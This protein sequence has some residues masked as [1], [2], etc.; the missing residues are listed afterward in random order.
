MKS[1]NPRQKLLVNA[2]AAAAMGYLPTSI[3]QNAEDI[4]GLLEEIVVTATAREQTVQEIPYNISAI[5]GADIAASQI[6]GEADLLRSIAGVG[7]IDRGDRNAGTVNSII[8]RGLNVDNGSSGDNASNAVAAVSTYVDN[9]PLYARFVL[10]DIQRVEVLRGPQGT[11]YGS[12]SLGGTVRYISNKPN[13]EE[14][15][16]SV[17]A[18]YGEVNGSGGH[19]QTLDMMLNVP[20]SDQLAIRGHIGKVD[21]DGS[22]D[23]INAYQLNEF[24]EPLLDDG[25][26][27]CLD[28]R[29]A[30][31]Q[32]VLHNVGCFTNR[33]DADTVELEYGRVALQ[34]EPSESLSFLLAYQTQR[35]KVGGRRAI[36]LGDNNQ[37]EGSPLR[38]EYGDDDIGLVLTEPSSRDVDMLA[39]DVE[40]DLGFATL[41]SNTSRYDHEG[42]GERDNGG[43]WTSVNSDGRGD[44][45]SI[46]YPGWARPAHRT[47]A[48][49]KDETFVQ[50]F[51]LVSN[52]SD[53]AFDWLAGVFYLDQEK[54]AYSDSFNPGMNNWS[55]ACARTNDP[56]CAGFWPYLFAAG[57]PL[58]ENDFEYERNETFEELAVYGEVTWHLSQKLRVTGGL[59]WFDNESVADGVMG[60]PLLEGDSS[61]VVQAN[62]DEDSGVLLKVNASYDLSETA[63]VYGTISEGYRRG[64]ANSIPADGPFAEP[65]AEAVSAYERDTVLNYEFGVKGRTDSLAYTLSAFYID[66]ND[67]Q[68]NTASTFG[69]LMADNGD[70]AHTLG[71]E[72][73]LDGYIGN[74]LHYRFGYTWTEAEL[75]SDFVGTQ[76]G[77]VIAEKGERLPGSA[78]HVLSLGIDY[79]W[80]V[81]DGM[82]LVAQANGYY[83]SDSENYIDNDNDPF[84][85]THDGFMLWGASASLVTEQW[86]L[87]LY[88]K[89]LGN[90]EATGGSW[91][92]SVRTYDNG[93]FEGWYGN[94]NL[95]FIA[96]PRTIGLSAA[97]KF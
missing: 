95:Q 28:P 82:D 97:Y 41:T 39:L 85:Q 76:L 37:P 66:W 2:I 53:G 7:V 32:Q 30:S 4:G 36:T 16:G 88:G 18:S 3:A 86:S 49:F 21:N 77:N 56:I 46:L 87:V 34:Y 67:P 94:A 78:E 65:N 6:T 52:S 75:D 9:T 63:M 93:T 74:S 26:G 84:S 79:T 24:G 19:N 33:E 38:F 20:I 14:F 91:P 40:W 13:T 51:R 17:S 72:V 96:Q 27:N 57:V 47:V 25:N 81:A 8:I 54:Q 92:E 83:Q 29:Q 31:D 45:A 59:R 12:G 22:I 10:K 35:D 90:E 60:F 68:I 61:P 5:S 42:V 43:L 69:F 62:V 11:L 1:P 71:L 80:P 44:W 23:Y 15:E 73:E 55:Q 70:S 50:E 89:N 58:S 64:G 48:G